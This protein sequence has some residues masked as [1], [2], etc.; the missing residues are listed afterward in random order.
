MRNVDIAMR[1]S[2]AVPRGLGVASPIAVGKAL[3]AELWDVEGRRYIDFAGGIGVVNTGHCHPSIVA[4]ARKQLDAFTHVSIQ[5][6]SYEGYV[7]LAETLND[8]APGDKPKKTLL[9][10]TGAEAVENAVKIARYST[11]RSAVLSYSGAFHGRTLLTLGLTGKVRPYKQGFGPFP[12]DLFHLPFPEAS[13]DAIQKS[14]AALDEL[15]R[16][17]ADPSSVAA[18]L[19]EPVQGEGGFNIA[20]FGFLQRLREIANQ[21]GILLIVD[22]I[23]S[24]FGRTGRFFAIEH[25]GVVPDLITAAKSLAGGFPLAAVIGRADVMDA[26]PPGGL[27]GTYAG[28][29]LS[30]AAALSV[31]DVIRQEKLLER[32][33]ALGA[34]MTARLQQIKSEVDCVANVR[35]LGAMVAFDI[36]VSRTD[37]PDSQRAM[38]VT[39]AAAERGLIVLAC[40]TFGN[41]IRILVPLTA[42]NEIV[43]EGLAILGA[44]IGS[45]QTEA[46][47]QPINEAAKAA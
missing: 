11:G 37:Q 14:L 30:C 13:Q 18:I 9:V 38:A 26:V 20:P 47:A 42:T 3:N 19:I 33:A 41:V 46:G 15:F 36:V 16:T 4:A 8:L 34:R 31:I 23:Q 43:E 24:G 10:T 1:R 12:S 2:N 39:R 5:V 25:S 45:T 6:A 7:R 32:S 27:G 44:A 22:E 40:G 29:P 35:G 17:T 28:N 21:Y